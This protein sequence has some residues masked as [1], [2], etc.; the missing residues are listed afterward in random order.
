MY[1]TIN[2]RRYRFAPPVQETRTIP[3]ETWLTYT[4]FAEWYRDLLLKGTT[5]Y[6]GNL[7][8][9]ACCFTLALLGA[10]FV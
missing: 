6:C 5:S 2:L 8:S 1:L 3:A 4:A 9:G 10:W 7:S